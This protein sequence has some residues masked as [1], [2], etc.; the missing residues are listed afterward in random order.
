MCRVIL[1]KKYLLPRLV[2]ASSERE[3]D[4]IEEQRPIILVGIGR[5]G[6]IVHD[7]LIMTGHKPTVID[8]DPVLIAGM[9]KMGVKTYYGDATRKE[10][11]HAAGIEHAGVLIVAVDDKDKAT[12]VVQIARKLNPQI[13]IIS[14]AYDRVHVFDLYQ[15]GSDIQVRETFDSAVR[16]G[17]KVLR[18]LGTV[19]LS[20]LLS[21]Q[22]SI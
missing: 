8:Q 18:V 14:R 5:F 11:L 22:K 19:E 1:H 16:A 6:Q 9:K 13:K 17:K 2:A 7:L 4:H 15:A 10:L 21:N 12:R 20:S 3:A